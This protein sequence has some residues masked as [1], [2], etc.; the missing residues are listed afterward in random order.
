MQ[1]LN[2]WTTATWQRRTI[3][4]RNQYRKCFSSVLHDLISQRVALLFDSI[5]NIT[6]MNF[7]LL[8]LISFWIYE[9]E[10]TYFFQVQKFL[11][12]ERKVVFIGEGISSAKIFGFLFQNGSSSEIVLFWSCATNENINCHNI[13]IQKFIYFQNENENFDLSG[14]CAFFPFWFQISHTCCINLSSGIG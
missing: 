12:N 13:A 1:A 9:K 4:K 5:I 14:I 6:K 3:V 11:L 2:P 8:M 10:F 7:I